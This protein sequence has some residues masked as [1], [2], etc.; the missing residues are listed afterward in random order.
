[1]IHVSLQ[2]FR[3]PTQ[4][5]SKVLAPTWCNLEVTQCVLLF[6]A[7]EMSEW[8]LLRDAPAEGKFGEEAS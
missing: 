5:L 8:I 6:L 1:M 4:A 2:Y 3:Y 7:S